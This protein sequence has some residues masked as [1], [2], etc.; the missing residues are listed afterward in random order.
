MAV[1][2]GAVIRKA[3]LL[4]IAVGCL[5][6]GLALWLLPGGSEGGFFDRGDRV[7]GAGLM[8][9]G[10]LAVVLALLRRARPATSGGDA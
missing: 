6:L 8:A 3:G 9:A 4:L 1:M 10:V 7:S 5:A 2:R